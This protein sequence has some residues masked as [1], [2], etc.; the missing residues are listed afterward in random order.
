M[1]KDIIDAYNKPFNLKCLHIFVI[2]NMEGKETSVI[3]MICTIKSTTEKRLTTVM[4][5]QQQ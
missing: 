1:I 5:T 3:V 4:M 2:M